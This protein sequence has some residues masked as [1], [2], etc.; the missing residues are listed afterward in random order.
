MKKFGE[1]EF[2]EKVMA[3]VKAAKMKAPFVKAVCYVDEHGVPECVNKYT[4][5]DYGTT[6]EFEFTRVYEN[7]EDKIMV[8]DLVTRKHDNYKICSHLYEMVDA[9]K[10]GE[11][12]FPF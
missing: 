12:V 4:V 2:G 8:T 9:L 1:M 11:R 7:G 3:A 10:N 6:A 5:I